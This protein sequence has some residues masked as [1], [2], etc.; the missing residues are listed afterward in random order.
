[1]QFNVE[2]LVPAEK[3]TTFRDLLTAEQLTDLDDAIA[4][5]GEDLFNHLKAL[6]LT[7]KEHR[8][9]LPRISPKDDDET[10]ESKSKENQDGLD[11][12]IGVQIYMK[13]IE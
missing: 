7:I 3:V 13:A 2:K 5:D 6:K 8:R 4:L 9:S 10:K 11:M 1:M 12:W